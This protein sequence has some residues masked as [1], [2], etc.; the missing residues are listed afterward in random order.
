MLCGGGV[1]YKIGEIYKI[2]VMNPDYNRPFVYTVKILSEDANSIEVE[3]KTGENRIFLKS[4]IEDAVLC[5]GG[6]DEKK[7]K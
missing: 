4:K 6:C 2:R 1:V 7:Y 3:T 5:G